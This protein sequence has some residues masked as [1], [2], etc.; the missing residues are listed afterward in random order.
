M[1]SDFDYKGMDPKLN[2]KLL[3]DLQPCIYHKFCIFKSF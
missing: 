1:L 3:T 2:F